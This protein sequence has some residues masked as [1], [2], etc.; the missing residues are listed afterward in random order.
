MKS[1]LVTFLLL[2]LTGGFSQVEAIDVK[3]SQF[4]GFWIMI[5]GDEKPFVVSVKPWGDV[6]RFWE[7]DDDQTIY[8]GRWRGHPKGIQFNWKDFPNAVMHRSPEGIDV[9][10]Y[11]EKGSDM[12]IP[13][14]KLEKGLVG[15]GLT[16]QDF[17]NTY[18]DR[19]H[20][21]NVDLTERQKA[22]KTPRPTEEEI[23]N[24]KKQD[25]VDAVKPVSGVRFAGKWSYLADDG[26]IFEVDLRT[27]GQVWMREQLSAP[28]GS[29][30]VTNER[31]IVSYQSGWQQIILADPKSASGFFL[32]SVEPNTNRTYR[33]PVRK[34]GEPVYVIEDQPI[35]PATAVPVQ[36]EEA[37][38]AAAGDTETIKPTPSSR[39]ARTTLG[40]DY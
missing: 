36:S 9:M 18:R 22:Y 30:M 39:R 8:K 4:W 32:F 31:A 3:N 27:S 21:L 28:V 16:A 37:P 10:V 13:M 1:F 23:I 12:V 7:T 35:S 20:D 33:F 40:F 26:T 25:L 38:A 29:W 2:V 15:N 11:E 19:T 5:G 6:T 17:L 14:V 24:T 34:V